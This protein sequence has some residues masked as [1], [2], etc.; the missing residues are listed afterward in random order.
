MPAEHIMLHPLPDE[1][2]E[3]IWQ[4]F[5]REIGGEYSPGGFWHQEQIAL[6][7]P[8]Y[9]I[10]IALT[11]DTPSVACT[12]LSASYSTNDGLLFS[13]F[14]SDAFADTGPLQKLP[15]ILVGNEAFDTRFRI[16][17]TDRQQVLKLLQNDAIRAY[18]MRV[19]HIGLHTERITPSPI[20]VKLT[21][22]VLGT[23]SHRETLLALVELM[24][25]T[26]QH[27]CAIGSAKEE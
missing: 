3:L 4:R 18:L 27:L 5:A 8:P 13:I 6:V 25:E 12:E 2:R 14:D 21:C 26:L 16:A 11:K 17:G 7:M 24:G 9:A 22:T 20:Q 15:E 23:V 19:P 10:T 1:P